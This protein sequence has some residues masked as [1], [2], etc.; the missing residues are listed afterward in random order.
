VDPT[1]AERVVVVSSLGI[2]SAS[3]AGMGL[4]NG[5]HDPWAD[6]IVVERFRYVQ[7]SAFYDQLTDVPAE[8]L[9]ELPDNPLGAWIASKQPNLWGWA[10]ASDQVSVLAAA[11]PEF[12]TGVERAS[13]MSLAADAEVGPDLLLD[14]AGSLWL[15]TGCEGVAATERFWEVLLDVSA[16]AP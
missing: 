15:V 7:V 9:A 2:A 5:D 6:K 4:P 16:R 14:P 12:V 3:G 13:P 8:R 11:W 1:V 10:P